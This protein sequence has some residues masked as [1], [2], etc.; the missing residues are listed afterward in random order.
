MRN[1]CQHL[2]GKLVMLS[3]TTVPQEF[4]LERERKRLAA[5]RRRK[6]YL[7]RIATG[8]TVRDIAAA[9]G[10]STQAVYRVLARTS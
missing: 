8:E 4:I 10:I 7:R 5:V 9:A 2:G 3:S 1:A 6:E